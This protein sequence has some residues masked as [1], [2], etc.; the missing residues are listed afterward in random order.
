MSYVYKLTHK[1]TGQFYIGY[2]EAN[3]LCPK[4]D[5]PIYQTSS[6]YVKE[7]GFK[8]FNWEIIKDFDDAKDAF[9]L[10]Q[11]MIEVNFQDPLCLNRYYHKGKKPTRKT[12][13]VKTKD[14]KKAE[15]VAFRLQLTED[16]KHLPTNN[17]NRKY[18]G[19]Y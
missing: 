13:S 18:P 7:I 14:E 11:S 3:K 10:E 12:K 9:A 2:R 5:L 4:E 6:I 17:P 19:S 8:K 15:K 16:L 1:V